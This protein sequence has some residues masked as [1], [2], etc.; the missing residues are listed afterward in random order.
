MPDAFFVTMETFSSAGG[1]MELVKNQSQ[2]RN[3]WSFRLW[4]RNASC[5]VIVTGLAVRVHKGDDDDDDV[6]GDDSNNIV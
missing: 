2:N 4:G 3:S 6:N 5:N 1:L